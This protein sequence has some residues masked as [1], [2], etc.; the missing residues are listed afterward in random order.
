MPVVEILLGQLP[1]P[2]E[3][4]PQASWLEGRT[5]LFAMLFLGLLGLAAFGLLFYRKRHL[6]GAVEERFKAFRHQSVT[7]MDQLD[8]LRKRHK[9]LPA[10]DPDF[11]VP[12][13]GATLAL[14]SDVNRDLDGLWERWL[15][16]MEIWDQAQRRIRAGAGL[17]LKPTEEARKLLE[18]GEIDEL[19]RQSTSCQERLDKLNQAHEQ[20]HED[21]GTARAE[22]AAIQNSISKGTGVLLPN[23]LHHREIET[24]ETAL[25]D[26]ETM[27]TADPI[28]AEDLIRRARNSLSSLSDR[29]DRG[30][31]R[32]G[33]G[34]TS[35]PMIDELAAAAERLRAA[36]ARLGVTGL[37]GLFIKAWIAVW[38]VGLLFGILLPFLVPMIILAGFVIMLAGGVAVLRAM[39]SWFWFGLG[40]PRR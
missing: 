31:G 9:S 37:I 7:L 8:A 34:P 4:S 28:G 11:T 33:A 21:L 18:G 16:V 22:L 13:E 1:V 38:V 29:P 39:T 25:A 10:T 40:G 14:Y 19:V 3:T 24:A 35:H 6:Q 15:S 12:M 36:A 26:A 32:Y 23:D 20:A 30:L 17:A 27:L 5:P 2:L